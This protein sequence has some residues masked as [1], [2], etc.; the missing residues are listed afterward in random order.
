[1]T[2]SDLIRWR[3]LLGVSVEATPDVLRQAYLRKSYALIQRGASEEEK[4]TLRQAHEGLVRHAEKRPLRPAPTAAAPIRPVP[5]Y[6]PPSPVATFDPF[7]FES[8]LVDAVAAPLVALVAILITASPLQFFMTGFHIWIHEFGHATVAWLSGKR[9]I[10]LPIGWTNIVFE[11]SY[12]VYFGVLLLLAILFV[13]GWREKRIAAMVAAVLLALAQF[14]MTW[15]MPEETA[16]M[17]IAFGGIGG[18]Y[19]LSTAA[20]I[21]FYFQLPEKFRW[22]ACRYLF[23]FFAS[24]R[25]Y[26]TFTFWRRVQ[27]GTEG[28]PYGSMV[29]G[30]DDKSGDMDTLVNDFHWT[31]HK[32]SGTYNHLGTVCVAAVI[33]VYLIFASGLGRL[34]RHRLLTLLPDRE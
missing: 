21:L 26:S 9:A 8:P 11:R 19:C 34:I 1:M 27:A 17:W 32:V 29:N 23:L 16:R 33:I 30:E 4:E 14:W 2:E 5:V 10:P 25:L 20:I 13:A 3:E 15:I 7:S 31:Q 24:G 6:V 22:G 12:F 18:E 28:I